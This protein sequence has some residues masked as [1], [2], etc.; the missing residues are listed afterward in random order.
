MVSRSL[1]RTVITLHPPRAMGV[2]AV[3]TIQPG[4]RGVGGRASLGGV[5]LCAALSVLP[6]PLGAQYASRVGVTISAPAVAPAVHGIG[7]QRA[8]SREAI[9]VRPAAPG[10]RRLI[11][12][13]ALVGG[14]AGGAIA[15]GV[16]TS[17]C[18]H[19]DDPAPVMVA[20]V[21]GAVVGAIIGGVTGALW[22]ERA[23]GAARAFQL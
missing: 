12:L 4:A 20:A 23:P 16:A 19:C 11:V 22:R 17:S 8:L 15:Y 6:K 3:R 21:G 13:G 1:A 7:E 18:D 5:A 9:R 2:P 14:V 10:R